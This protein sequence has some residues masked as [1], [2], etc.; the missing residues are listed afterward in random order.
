MRGRFVT[1]EGIDASG[2]SSLV[3]GLVTLLRDRGCDAVAIQKKQTEGYT[4]PFV[5]RAMRHL[6][7]ML[8]DATPDDPVAMLAESSWTLMHTLWYEVMQEHLIEPLLARHAVVVSDGWFY[9]F[10]ARHLVHAP[11]QATRTSVVMQNVRDADL[12]LLLDVSAEECWARR[13]AF[14]PSELGAHGTPAPE[15]TSARDQF[16][17]YQG[18]VSA[19]LHAM[20]AQPFW[21]TI[22]AGGKTPDR[23]VAQM[24]DAVMVVP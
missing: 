14:R 2:K 21:R 10:L 16:L 17:A 5:E 12:V 11:G 4:H 6:R 1:I 20:A 19:E 3:S 23:I 24:A 7:A 15:A 9:K 18:R 22:D 13:P 8:W